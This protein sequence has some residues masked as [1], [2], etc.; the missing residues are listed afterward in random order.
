MHLHVALQK[1]TPWKCATQEARFG[2]IRSR[3]LKSEH[4]PLRVSM[5]DSQVRERS[6]FDIPTSDLEF[7]RKLFCRAQR[8]AEIT[9]F[10]IDFVRSFDGLSNF[11][12][13]QRAI[14]FA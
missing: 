9:E 13:E 3:R 5:I 11:F 6:Y 10:V 7:F 2:K 14:A 1:S 12:A 4:R 8:R